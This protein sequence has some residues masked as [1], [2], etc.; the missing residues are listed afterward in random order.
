M[1]NKARA[2]CVIRVSV[3]K[4]IYP[5]AIHGRRPSHYSVDL[6]SLL[7]EELSQVRTVLPSDAT[8]ERF[9]SHRRESLGCSRVSA[10]RYSQLISD[11]ASIA[12]NIQ[13]RLD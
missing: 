3:L 2:C 6:V 7:Q 5:S 9:A 13:D 12:S 1:K 11:L 4:V 8:D 10:K